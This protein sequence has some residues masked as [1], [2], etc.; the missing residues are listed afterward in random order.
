MM[1]MGFP[2]YVFVILLILL[3]IALVMTFYNYL[4][5]LEP[6]SDEPE[7][8]SNEIVQLETEI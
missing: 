8:G 3:P 6:H 4:N 1:S 5:T 2:F 7:G